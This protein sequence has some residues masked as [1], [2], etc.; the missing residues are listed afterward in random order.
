MIARYLEIAS[1]LYPELPLP[2]DRLPYTEAFEVIHERFC[3]AAGQSVSRNAVWNAFVSLRKRGRGTR[4]WRGVQ[5]N[6]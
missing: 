3:R 4:R 5:L 1:T 2:L 6:S